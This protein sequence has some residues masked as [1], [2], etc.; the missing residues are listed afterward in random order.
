[1]AVRIAFIVE[2]KSS[3]DGGI[4]SALNPVIMIVS[5]KGE[6]LKKPLNVPK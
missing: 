5:T 2:V 3:D 1:V 6:L 4:Y